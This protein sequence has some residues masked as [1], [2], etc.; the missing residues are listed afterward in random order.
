[1][2]ATIGKAV[3][4]SG[5]HLDAI[6]RSTAL[7][8]ATRQLTK[9][10]WETYSRGVSLNVTYALLPWKQPP[11]GVAIDQ[12]TKSVIL[13]SANAHYDRMW[14]SFI[15]TTAQEG[16]KG[17]KRYADECAAIRDK[18]Q[19]DLVWFFQQVAADQA[20]AIAAAQSGVKAFA[21]L[22]MTAQIG[23]AA[24]GLGGAYVLVGGAAYIAAGV[25]VAGSMGVSIAKNW[26]EAD[27]FGAVALDWNKE[28]AKFFVGEGVNL[29]SDHNAAQALTEIDV[30]HKTIA[31][32]EKDIAKH[33]RR[34]GNKAS[35]KG[36]RAGIAN[37]QAAKTAGARSVQTGTTRA[38]AAKGG[39]LI[40]KALPV[41][42]FV[43]EVYEAY[44]DYDSAVNGR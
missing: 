20:Q 12:A 27:A 29:V 8:V 23:L 5:P 7:A 30:G 1:M 32:A 38:A 19:A 11:G 14:E 9:S 2:A 10:K 24:C 43:A 15:R 6:F 18:A 37:A 40:G 17:A 28:S 13:G 39:Q 4:F 35:A 3:A 21:G 25:G 26:G 33:T 36:A 22:K 31:K 34:I 44:G 16:A 42:F 41:L